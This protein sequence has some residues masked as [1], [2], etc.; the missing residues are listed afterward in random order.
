V[1]DLYEAEQQQRAALRLLKAVGLLALVIGGV[2]IANITVAAIMERTREIGL[3]RAIG[4]TDL[5]VM[6]QFIAEAALLSLV[7]G[8]TAVTTVHLLTKVATTTIFE[9]PYRF[10]P[11]DAAIAMGAAFAVG[12]GSSLGPAL[13]ITRI[14]V[15]S[16]L[17]GE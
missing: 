5:E 4:A 10:Q 2:G 14:D 8:L 7:G 16:A 13:R 6:G 15:V 12:V 11:R 17:R 9:A 1:E 3:R